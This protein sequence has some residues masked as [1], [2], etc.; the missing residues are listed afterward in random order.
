MDA[1]GG[2]KPPVNVSPLI[3]VSIFYSVPFSVKVSKVLRLVSR[4][5]VLTCDRGRSRDLEFYSE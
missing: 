3:R 2:F 4:F 1:V 5:Y